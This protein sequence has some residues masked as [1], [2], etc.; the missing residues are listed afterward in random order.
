ALAAFQAA[1]RAGE[2]VVA[3]E[4]FGAAFPD[5]RW[6]HALPRLD[7]AYSPA[8][9]LADRARLWCETAAVLRERYRVHPLELA[10]VVLA[11]AAE[12]PN[13]PSDGAFGGFCS[14]SF[15]FLG[16]LAGAPSREW[17][18]P[19]RDRYH[20]V[21]REPLVE[22]CEAVAARYVRPVLAG[23]YGWDLETDTRPGRALTSIVKNDFGRS[24]P[25]QPVQWLTFY[26]RSQ[27]NKRADA[28]FFVR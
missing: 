21:L 5:P 2:F 9:E 28:Q 7:D 13:A 15:R 23:E 17:M 11:V 16:E 27:A 19:Q 14:D 6:E 10:D 3:W 4:A 8:L 18:A 22:L 25:Y 26:R 12:E 1:G 20:F 24:S